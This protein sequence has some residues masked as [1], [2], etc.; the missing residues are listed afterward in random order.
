M[1]QSAAPRDGK[2]FVIYGAGGIGGVLGAC[3]HLAG[4]RVALIARGAH[5]EAIRRDGL[6]LVSGSTTTRVSIPVADRPEALD[7]TEDDVIV[8]AMQAQDTEEA[9][10]ALS[11]CAPE[12]IPIV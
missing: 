5:Y 9:V 3:L 11:A 12:T 1:S 10:R 2:R 6:D 4:R 7:L 8:L